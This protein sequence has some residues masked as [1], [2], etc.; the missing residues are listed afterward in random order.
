MSPST[1]NDLQTR[2]RENS[3]TNSGVPENQINNENQ[4]DNS[5]IKENT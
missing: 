5:A 2:I 3:I 4:S 1:E